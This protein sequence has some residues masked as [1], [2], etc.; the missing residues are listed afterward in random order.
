MCVAISK[1][2]LKKYCIINHKKG[3]ELLVE[4]TIQEDPMLGPEVLDVIS[5]LIE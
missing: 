3:K 2:K 5:K 1:V 4:P